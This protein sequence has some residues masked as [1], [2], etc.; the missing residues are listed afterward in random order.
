MKTGIKKYFGNDFVAFKT[1][2]DLLLRPAKVVNTKDGYVPPFRFMLSVVGFLIFLIVFLD[3]YLVFEELSTV[4]WRIPYRL[5]MLSDLEDEISEDFMGL[6]L[7]SSILP[8]IWLSSRLLFFKKENKAGQFRTSIYLVTLVFILISVLTII[9]Y[10]F[11]VDVDDIALLM[12]PLYTIYYYVQVSNNR[13][14]LSGPKAILV[15]I[16]GFISLAFFEPFLTHSFVTVL[17]QPDQVIEVTSDDKALFVQE[18]RLHADVEYVI[19]IE[20]TSDG[21]F[22][23]DFGTSVGLLDRDGELK[24]QHNVSFNRPFLVSEVNRLLIVTR[25]TV[26]HGEPNSKLNF[27]SFDGAKVQE[28][29]IQGSFVKNGYQIINEERNQLD[30]L[31]SALEAEN[32][33]FTYVRVRCVKN[34]D[35]EWEASTSLFLSSRH[36][37]LNIQRVG[38]NEY[39]GAKVELGDRHYRTFGIVVLDSL[40]NEK[41]HHITYDKINSYNPVVPPHYAIN[42]QAGEVITL[43]SLPNDSMNTS[44]LHCFDL[45]DGSL[46]WEETFT[47]PSDFSEYFRMSFDDRH[48]YIVGESH[49]EIKRYFWQVPFHIGLVCKVDRKSG[50]LVSY[51][52]FG[53]MGM[54]AHTRISDLIL[55]D[56][57]LRLFSSQIIRSPIPFVDETYEHYYWDILKADI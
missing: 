43:Y 35:G 27:Y 44:F 25:D 54:N 34:G 3:K 14:Y 32:D 48:L 16:T 23:S 51:K 15:I 19:E 11:Q 24:W 30:L 42:E 5:Q 12:L 28:I 13:W 8:G 17:N 21:V 4:H 22:F 36:S 47:I 40:L 9:N 38:A 6:I 41:W 45:S 53:S 55:S 49:S 1:L 33:T 50:Q 57:S 46:K 20:P 52:H 31:L 37:L 29:I 2:S 7:I 18:K 26:I 56:S 10:L 39:I